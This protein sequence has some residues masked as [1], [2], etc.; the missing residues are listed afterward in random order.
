MENFFV[1]CSEDVD[2][3]TGD[4]LYDNR[5][6]VDGN[7]LRADGIAM[8]LPFSCLYFKNLPYDLLI[9][10][11]DQFI[12]RVNKYRKKIEE[13]GQVHDRIL[14]VSAKNDSI[15][16]V[17]EKEM[18]LFNAY[19][20]L[21]RSKALDS[22]EGGPGPL[23]SCKIVWADDAFCLVAGSGSV[24]YSLSLEIVSAIGERIVDAV[25]M[26]RYNKFACAVGGTVRF[27]EPN[28]LEHG[29]PLPVDCDMLSLLD[30]D[31]AKVLVAGKD[32]RTGLYYMK[33]FHWYKKAEVAGRLVCCE[34]NT[35]LTRREGGLARLYVYR[36]MSEGLVVDG[37]G[38]KYTDLSKAIIP[39]PYC[40]SELVLGRQIDDLH[41]SGDSLYILSGNRIHQYSVNGGDF[42]APVLHEIGT[43]AATGVVVVGGDIIIRA[44][45]AVSRLEDGR[46]F[47][48]CHPQTAPVLRLYDI[49]GRLG[50]LL[51]DG[52]LVLFT[53]DG[54]LDHRVFRFKI[55]L[56]RSLDLQWH[57][58]DAMDLN[59]RMEGIQIDGRGELTLY[60]LCDG[61]LQVAR[62][63]GAEDQISP[64]A[65]LH[66]TSFLCFDGYVIYTSK[67]RLVVSE[68]GN[69]LSTSYADASLH[70]LAVK[71]NRIICQTRFGT[72][73]TVT[74]KIFS[75]RLIAGHIGGRR[76]REAACLCDKHHIEYDIFY[77][78]GRCPVSIVDELEDR[79]VLSLVSVLKVEEPVYHENDSLGRLRAVF[80]PDMVFAADG[81]STGTVP[82]GLCIWSDCIDH[83][84]ADPYRERQFD[85]D[86]LAPP[87]CARHGDSIDLNC[88]SLSLNTVLRRLDPRKHLGAVVGFFIALRRIDLCFYL[89]DLEKAIKLLFN[90]VS[91]NDI[92]KAAVSTLSLEKM[93]LA[94]KV[95]Q[96]DY[97]PFVDF[98]NSRE[99]IPF[100]MYDYLEDRRMALYHLVKGTGD[101][102]GRVREYVEKHNLFD[103]LLMYQYFG[104]FPCNFSC[105]VAEHVCAEK[106]FV[107]FMLGGDRE[108]ALAAAEKDVLWRRALPFFDEK[109]V[110]LRFIRL[111]VDRGRIAEAAEIHEKYLGE[112]RSAVELYIRG[113]SFGEALLVYK[114]NGLGDMR[115]LFTDS[116]KIALKNEIAELGI[117]VSSYDKYRARIAQVRE[118][119]NESVAMSQTSF[120]YTSLKSARNALVRDRPGGAYENE[121]V[122]NKIRGLV[123]Q[124]VQWRERTESLL[125][126]FA[127]FGMEECVLAHN[128]TFGDVRKRLRA[129]VDEVWAFERSDYDPNRPVIDKPAVSEWFD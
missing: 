117:L 79:H 70:L 126:V 123:I 4:Y 49:S 20:D 75:R 106:A 7:V 53:G 16:I 87:G 99:N 46:L 37:C 27:I 121:Y 69:T 85:L 56:S 129:E 93:I 71:D 115:G 59:R 55:N 94:H 54:Y 68:N 3:D 67:D 50:I 72:L 8:T 80:R 84:F 103:E 66:I 31:G 92:L 91:A 114:S 73:E 45:D 107:L 76:Y 95:C 29:D 57:T 118:R 44:G 34:G 89:P 14:G 74:N 26:S 30:V 19:F 22:A 1:R 5:A 28:G 101:I 48:I 119:L 33:N 18:M 125:R 47:P 23:D 109:D 41:R 65:A 64:Y 104:L 100:S 51:A 25:F 42:S 111:L 2:F 15:L 11:E 81:A 13:I 39:P 110:Q 36:E 113:N 43:K 96:S 9:V 35:V 77:C 63:R 32:D 86:L 10:S 21:V 108:K 122:L 58:S 78:D 52:G 112:H 17:T 60:L 38:L 40:Y 90:R 62:L 61:V 24:I 124:V 98:Y 105:Y 102:D 83:L 82:G 6:C 88:L 120:S 12:Y 128:R 127:E 97:T 116:S